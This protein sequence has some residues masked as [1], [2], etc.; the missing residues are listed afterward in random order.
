VKLNVWK[1]STL[2]LA[3]ALAFV[4]GRGALVSVASAGPQ[5]NMQAALQSLEAAHRS[6]EA[7]TADKG[8]HRVKAIALT[9]EAI[10]EVKKGI[11]FDDT[12]SGPA[13]NKRPRK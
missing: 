13:E 9:K 8:G 6:L 1:I 2:V 12:H 3:G 11:A 10:E 7:A 4:A 5:P